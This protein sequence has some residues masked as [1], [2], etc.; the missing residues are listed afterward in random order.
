MDYGPDK[1]SGAVITVETLLHCVCILCVCMC[2]WVGGSTGVAI[3]PLAAVSPELDGCRSKMCV[4]RHQG[5][6]VDKKR[7]TC[8]N[9]RRLEL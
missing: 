8:K 5:H 3:A 4:G 9:C 7:T 1:D 2:V 6:P